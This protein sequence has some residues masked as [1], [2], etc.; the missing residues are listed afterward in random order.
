MYTT[1]DVYTSYVD[2]IHF[3]YFHKAQTTLV[4][5]FLF[6]DFQWHSVKGWLFYK[7]HY[8]FMLAWVCPSQN[9]HLCSP[10]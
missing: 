5:N 3:I 2:N 7:M 9:C 4:V 10:T 8:C 1:R 6:Q